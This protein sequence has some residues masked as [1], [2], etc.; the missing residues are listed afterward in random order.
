MASTG[1]SPYEQTNSISL[2]IP[3]WRLKLLDISSARRLPIPFIS[4][5]FS[6]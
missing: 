6:G 1:R 3:A 4:A 2:R 5:N